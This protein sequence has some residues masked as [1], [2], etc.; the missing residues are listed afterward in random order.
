MKCLN[1]TNLNKTLSLC[2]PKLW[3]PASEPRAAASYPVSCSPEESELA[4]TRLQLSL[5]PMTNCIGQLHECSW[6]DMIQ[7]PDL[8][9][10][11]N[12]RG[13]QVQPLVALLVLLLDLGEWTKVYES[14]H[15]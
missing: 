2:V 15:N 8:S 11:R 10:G 4:G 6:T 5:K 9:T 12:L 3:E 14:R 7:S 1:S 13:Q